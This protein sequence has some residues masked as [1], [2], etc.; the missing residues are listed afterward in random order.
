SV[1]PTGNASAN[2]DPKKSYSSVLATPQGMSSASIS[3]TGGSQAHTNLMPSLCVHF[4][5]A[6]FGIY[7]SR[8]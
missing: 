5:I 2:T 6:L 3:A 8:N 7:P 4:I 1:Y